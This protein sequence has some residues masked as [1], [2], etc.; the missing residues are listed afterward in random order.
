MYEELAKR[1]RGCSY[2]DPNGCEECRACPNADNYYECKQKLAL[3]AADA[4]EELIASVE[5]Y[6]ATTDMA[7]IEE[8]GST[9]IRFMPKWIPVTE[10]PPKAYEDVLLLFPHNQAAGFCD[11]DGCWGVYSGDGFYTEVADNEPKPTHWARKLP[12]PSK[13]EETNV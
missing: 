8:N 6:E 13:E 7:L 9:V 12:E 1:I 5:C 4:I 11:R 10:K 3:Q 2:S